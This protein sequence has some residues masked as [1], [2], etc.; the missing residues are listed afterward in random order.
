MADSG[1]KQL[2]AE[3]AASWARELAARVSEPNGFPEH[4]Q[5]RKTVTAIPAEYLVDELTV[6]I[7][8]LVETWSTAM[9]LVTL[10]DGPSPQKWSLEH[11][12][13]L[14]TRFVLDT[15]TI[16]ATYQTQ[17]LA[18][19]EDFVPLADEMVEGWL[20]TV[21]WFSVDG[22]LAGLL[23]NAQ[24]QASHA[25]KAHFMEMVRHCDPTM[26]REPEFWNH[27]AWQ[28]ARAKAQKLLSCFLQES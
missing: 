12:G 6:W 16:A 28:A 22:H 3:L 19:P 9:P 26:W 23:T 14:L 20:E 13:L 21:S 17:R 8:D 4:V 25:L 5:W 24:D 10:P 15:Q 11:F 18:I 27:P 7:Y 1:K 2:I